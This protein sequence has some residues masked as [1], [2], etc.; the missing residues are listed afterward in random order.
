MIAM[1]MQHATIRMEATFVNAIE[2]TLAMENKLVIKRKYSDQ[3]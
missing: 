1:E 2:V 3:F